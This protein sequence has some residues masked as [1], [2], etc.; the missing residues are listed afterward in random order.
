MMND[1]AFE[2]IKEMNRGF[3]KIELGKDKTITDIREYIESIRRWREDV[4][5]IKIAFADDIR[6]IVGI[7]VDNQ[8]ILRQFLLWGVYDCQTEGILDIYDDFMVL[9]EGYYRRVK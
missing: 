7:D 4:L 5:A 3:E 6:T 2:L 8:E 1:K 9:T